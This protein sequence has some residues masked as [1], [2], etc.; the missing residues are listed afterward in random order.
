MTASRAQLAA[1]RRRARCQQT[2]DVTAVALRA[3]TAD[4][5]GYIERRAAEL[6]APMITAALADAAA[7]RAAAAQEI[8]RRDDLADEL[9]RRLATIDR[10]L[11][12]WRRATGCRSVADYQMARARESQPGH[13]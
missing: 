12:G 2:P 1:V 10:Q 11:L 13:G 9:T 5:S 3:V 8:E 7:V 4:L 6:A